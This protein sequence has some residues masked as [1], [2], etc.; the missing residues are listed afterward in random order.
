MAISPAENPPLGHSLLLRDGDLVLER[1]RLAEVDGLANLMQALTLRV[2]TPLGSDSYHVGYGFDFASVL[3]EAGGQQAVRDMIRLNLVRALSAD[4]RV[5]EL[6][7]V[8]L[9]ADSADRR[10]WTVQVS[11]IAAGGRPQALTLSL[12]V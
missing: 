2:L 10:S 7:D 4:P 12:A 8:E 5:L 1:G 9:L 11:I 3:S 6:R